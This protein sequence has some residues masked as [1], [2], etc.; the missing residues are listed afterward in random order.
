MERKWRGQGLD[1]RFRGDDGLGVPGH[2]RRKSANR[3]SRRHGQNPIRIRTSEALPTRAP[4]GTRARN[5]A[6]HWLFGSTVKISGAGNP[7]MPQAHLVGRC[8]TRNYLLKLPPQA[9]D[10]ESM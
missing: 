5:S 4:A 9:A 8:E 6:L 3:V 1:P 2:N 10:K 7:Y